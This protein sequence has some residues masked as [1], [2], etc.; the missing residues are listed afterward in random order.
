[1]QTV[2]PKIK[3][4]SIVFDVPEV[5]STM[6]GR[7]RRITRPVRPQPP[8]ETTAVR[9]VPFSNYWWPAN[10]TVDS[11]GV[12]YEPLPDVDQIIC[13][14]GQRGDMLF[15][16]EPL[17]CDIDDGWVYSATG[18]EIDYR[19]CHKNIAC[20]WMETRPAMKSEYPASRM[21]R[22]ASRMTLEIT[23]VRV[24]QLHDMKHDDYV[25]EGYRQNEHV[26]DP[27]KWFQL[28]W[29]FRYVK[30]EFAWDKNPWAWHINFKMID[31]LL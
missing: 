22:W 1:M 2:R 9:D 27:V 20:Q 30:S 21:P 15:V 17:E 28:N 10:K 8:K 24:F 14:F 3:R 5:L 26:A 31:L 4:R 19:E 7:K 11:S 13:P 29:D 23:D 25:E 18:D 6:I 12:L 16:R